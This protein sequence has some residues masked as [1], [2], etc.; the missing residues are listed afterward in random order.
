MLIAVMLIVAFSYCYA[1]CRYVMYHYAEC[2]YAECCIFVL[3]CWMSL[4]YVFLSWVSLCYVSWHQFYISSRPTKTIFSE[5]TVERRFLIRAKH[6]SYI[7]KFQNSFRVFPIIFYALLK[8]SRKDIFSWKHVLIKLQN[9][10][11]IR[12]ASFDFV[13]TVIANIRYLTYPL[14]SSLSMYIYIFIWG[15]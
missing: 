3:L 1:E 2:R 12:L 6:F 13:L 4:C 14:M 11:Y 5:K 10:V 8:T 7:L 15:A 9:N